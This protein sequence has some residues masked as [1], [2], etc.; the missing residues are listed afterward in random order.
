MVKISDKHGRV[1]RGKPRD[2][3]NDADSEQREGF[4]DPISEPMRSSFR[5]HRR[6]R[7]FDARERELHVRSRDEKH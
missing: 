7:E 3:Y 2:L 6:E 5:G 4:E 1:R